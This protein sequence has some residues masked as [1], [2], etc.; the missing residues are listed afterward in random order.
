MKST[1][2]VSFSPSCAR[3]KI[4]DSGRTPSYGSHFD[5]KDTRGEDK[6]FSNG[7]RDF[8]EYFVL[9]LKNINT[10]CLVDTGRLLGNLVT[11]SGPVILID[12]KEE[13]LSNDWMKEISRLP[14]VTKE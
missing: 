11:G 7:K 2:S 3:G 8:E 4:F 13:K 6:S 9:A 5:H 12:A 10:A 1:I 14:K